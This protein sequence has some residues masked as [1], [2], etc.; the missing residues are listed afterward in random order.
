MVSQDPIRPLYPFPHMSALLPT[1]FSYHPTPF[2]YFTPDYWPAVLKF[3]KHKQTICSTG[4]ETALWF[5][6]TFPSGFT[7]IL[8]YDLPF[9]SQP[10]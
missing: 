7:Q 1:S 2:T 6:S 4:Q 5:T 3:G 10:I 9:S 8:K